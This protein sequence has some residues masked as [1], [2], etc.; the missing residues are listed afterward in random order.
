MH[1]GETESPGGWNRPLIQFD[2]IP[3]TPPNSIPWPF[4]SDT[5]RVSFF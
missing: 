1:A 5:F 2:T 3:W 4:Q